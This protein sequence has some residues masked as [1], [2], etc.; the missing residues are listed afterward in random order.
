[1]KIHKTHKSLLAS[2]GI[3]LVTLSQSQAHISYSGRNFGTFAGGE[4]PVIIS[5]QT[6]TGNFGWADGTDADFGD[7]HK[8]KAF[9]F[10]LTSTATVS[11]TVSGNAVGAGILGLNPGFTRYSGLAHLAPITN[12][13]GSADHDFSNISQDY[14]NGLGGPHEGAFNALATWRVGGDNQ[15]GPVFDYN[16]PDGLSTFTYI[17]HAVDGTAANYGNAP[18]IFG[19][20]LL[21]GTVTGTFYNLAAGN[22]SIFIGGSDYASQ[23]NSPVPTYGISA[24][25]MAVPEPST[26]LIGLLGATVL[27]RRKRN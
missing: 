23:L 26:G 8:M 9:R 14:L 15:A 27:L 20:G 21:D 2:A 25:F 22:Y 19:D 12:A 5:N 11:L 16:A 17:G 18:G 6:V 24:T 10:T 13:P 7:S 4:A 1:M 3:L